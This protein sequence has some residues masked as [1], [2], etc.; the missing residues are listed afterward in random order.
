M[1]PPHFLLAVFPSR[2]AINPALHLAE[3]LTRLGG[4]VTFF[5]TV[6]AI[7]H[8]IDPVC[9][10][11]YTF[12]TF[13]DGYD[14]G[15]EL[16]DDVNHFIA[17][18]KR[19]GSEAL[20]GFIEYSSGQGLRF[21]CVLNT[22]IPWADYVARSLQIPS[23]LIWIQPAT[24]FGVYH[25][26][27][28]GYGDVIKNVTS[29]SCDTTSL[30]RLP[31]L[32]PLT[33]RD[34]PSFFNL[35]NQYAFGLPQMQS[36]FEQ[37]K[38]GGNPKVVLVN[39][40][41]ALELE[42]LRSISTLNLVGIGPLVSFRV[43]DVQDHN[44]SDKSSKDDLYRGSEDYVQ[45]LNTK[46]EGSVI[47]VAFGSTSKFSKAQKREMARGLLET[48]RPFL[49]VMRKK[50]GDDDEL[51]YEE[52]LDK[53]GVIVPW[54]SQI[55]V[56]SHPSVGCFFTHCG[57]NSTL[58]SL[59]CGVPMVA[60][61]QFTDQM[62]NSKLVEDV[63]KV[64]VRLSEI[65]KEGIIVEGDEIKKCLELVMGG[66]ERGDGI[67]RNANKWKDL[68]R[69]ASRDGGSSDKNLKAFVE[70]FTKVD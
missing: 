51:I 11:A 28:N 43:L 25:H 55:T 1:A 12:T 19:Q 63:W 68:A 34:L 49:W 9:L 67:R 47:Y 3:R 23:V 33:N 30:I 65:D 17:E 41:D 64:G 5:T 66:G 37:L 35:K 22:M 4:H 60:F 31:G 36:Q 32:P 2:G 42:V 16:G 26:Y 56:L 45:W 59:V 29:Q 13:S 27:F 54:C 61:P 48:G 58:E 50:D 6:S 38:E 10:E 24:V 7:R 20:R 39:T 44:S 15:I 18:L 8:M 57:W 46:E 69:E 21:S 40:F 14:D 53:K 70:E 52:Q 62:T